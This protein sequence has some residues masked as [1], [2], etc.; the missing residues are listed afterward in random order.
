L[1]TCFSAY[2]YL[3]VGS[4]R[5]AYRTAGDAS[6]APVM[7]IHAFASQCSS[8]EAIAKTLASEGFRVIAPD[9][10]GH[11]RSARTATYALS[12]FE[13]D[14]IALLD[15]L[16]LHDVSLVGHSL[17]GHLVLRLAARQPRRVRKLVLEA[18]PVPPRDAAEAADMA[19]T[20]PG[21]A[22][23]HSLRLL[24]VGRLV[25]LLLLRQFD[26]RAALTVP[27][28][29]RK[30]MP[31]WWNCLATLSSPCLLLAGHDDGAVTQRLPL[32]SSHLPNATTR[33]FGSGHRLHGEHTEAF[34]AAVMPF[35][36]T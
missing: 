31:E 24:G 18:T 11:G 3:A 26:L 14:L 25:R 36:S 28:E 6:G 2:Q 22:W 9:L 20:R 15:A 34:L 32:L 23:R 12:E 17:G 27:R 29:L 5:L 30:P 21:P 16:D 10:R 19:A 1:A 13:Q 4:H 33:H 35:L 8:W 7:L